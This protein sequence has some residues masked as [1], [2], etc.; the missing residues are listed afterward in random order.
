MSDSAQQAPAA[1][2]APAPAAVPPPPPAAL[3]AVPRAAPQPRAGAGSHAQLNAAVTAAVDALAEKISQISEELS[4]ET[5][6]VRVRSL[7]AML[8]ECAAAVT[9][10][11]ALSSA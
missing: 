5:S 9:A 11:R 1:P 6:A 4:H 7:V 8:S 2:V 3:P 10:L